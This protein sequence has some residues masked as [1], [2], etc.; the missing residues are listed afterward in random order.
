MDRKNTKMLIVLFSGLIILGFASVLITQSIIDTKM[1]LLHESS[2]ENDTNTSD[3]TSENPTDN[4]ILEPT[5]VYGPIN[6]SVSEEEYLDELKAVEIR[7]AD[8][9]ANVTESNSTLSAAKYEKGIWDEQLNKIY[10]LYLNEQTATNT[11]KIKEE[12]KAF[13][14]ERERASIAAAKNANEALDGLVYNKE[15]AKL[16]KE[17]TY[18]YIER[19]Y[20]E[21]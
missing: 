6:S 14:S 17:K 16:T 11:E 13:I 15:Y 1:S 9:W 7:I 10:T 8:V 12:Q 3:V 18:E 5:S 2:I 19:Y 21:N 20:I 4:N